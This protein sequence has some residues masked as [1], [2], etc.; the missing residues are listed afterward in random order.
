M[1]KLEI[2]AIDV[3]EDGRERT[4]T[5]EH[6]DVVALGHALNEMFYG[7]LSNEFDYIEEEK[8]EVFCQSC[9]DNNWYHGGCDDCK[10]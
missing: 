6:I 10:S 4:Y 9:Q 7:Y 8:E 1:K 5:D 2:V 3:V